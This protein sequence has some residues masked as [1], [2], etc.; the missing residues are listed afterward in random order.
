[1]TPREKWKFEYRLMRICRREMNKAM[2]D[3]MH[4]GTGAVLF[5]KTISDGVRH[6]PLTELMA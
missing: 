1:M 2:E 3:V 4:F 5:D 6:I